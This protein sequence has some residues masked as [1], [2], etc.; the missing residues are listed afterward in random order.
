MGHPSKFQRV[1]RLGLVTAANRTLF[2]RCLAVSRAAALYIH[3]AGLIPVTEFCQL[4]NSL[5]VQILRS[6]ILAAL[7][8]GTRA[9][10]V[11]Q[12]LWRS[13]EGVT[14]I[15]Q[16]SYHIGHR[17]VEL[18]TKNIIYLTAPRWWTVHGGR[19]PPLGSVGLQCRYRASSSRP[20]AVGK[21]VVSGGRRQV[22]DLGGMH[23]PSLNGF[24]RM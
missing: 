11:T 24:D 3:F 16:G 13:A 18:A 17:P 19:S 21:K 12:T 7:L 14:Y 1:S 22:A 8:H 23:Q 15:R 6:R 4:Q 5:C 2:A 10:D 20:L 9:L